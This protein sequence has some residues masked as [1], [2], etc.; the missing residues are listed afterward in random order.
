MKVEKMSRKKVGTT[1]YC[2]NCRWDYIRKS[3][4]Q[5]WCTPCGLKKGSVSKE[6]TEKFIASL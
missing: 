3:R 4:Y 2:H 5:K 6:Y 1:G